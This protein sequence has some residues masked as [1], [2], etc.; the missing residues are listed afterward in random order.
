V[1]A[2]D[3]L[4]AAHKVYRAFG[5]EDGAVVVLAFIAGSG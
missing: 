2:Q 1:G 3:N 4:Q 5:Y